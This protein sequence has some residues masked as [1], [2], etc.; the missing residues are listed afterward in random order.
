[1]T[2]LI[3][4]I[5]AVDRRTLPKSDETKAKISAA[6]TGKKRTIAQR[7]TIALGKLEA[8]F[9]AELVNVR[10]KRGLPKEEAI[11]QLRRK[12]G[13]QVRRLKER[14]NEMTEA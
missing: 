10:G 14:Y 3:L 1:M 11:K 5:P 6:N 12:H 9:Q 13:Q 4:S 8:K 2:K 7:M